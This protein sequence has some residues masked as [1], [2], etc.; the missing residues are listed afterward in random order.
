MIVW[1]VRYCSMSCVCVGCLHNDW[2]I[3]DAT[4]TAYYNPKIQIRANE[5]E[6]LH[7]SVSYI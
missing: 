1:N 3:I 2:D 6:Y 4:N 5:P 7:W